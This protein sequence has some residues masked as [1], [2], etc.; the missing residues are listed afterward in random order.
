MA[1][2]VRLAIV[3]DEVDARR[4][5]EAYPLPSA[6]VGWG[7]RGSVEWFDEG[8]SGQ[9]RKSRHAE[10]GGEGSEVGDESN[11]EK[12]GRKSFTYI[13]VEGDVVRQLRILRC[14]VCCGVLGELNSVFME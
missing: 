7:G 3:D 5:R 1:V 6:A 11:G 10:G 8:W 13:V 14:A 9:R 2:E 12:V 4:G